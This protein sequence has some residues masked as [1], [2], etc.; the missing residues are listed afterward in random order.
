MKFSKNLKNVTFWSHH[1][2]PYQKLKRKLRNLFSPPVS[3][4][5]LD[6]H[7]HSN[8]SKSSSSINNNSNGN[9]PTDHGKE[10]L[11]QLEIE[12]KKVNDFLV[13]ERLPMIVNRFSDVLSKYKAIDFSSPF[14]V[15]LGVSLMSP[16]NER[17]QQQQQQQQQIPLQQV[18]SLALDQ[19]SSSLG[20]YSEQQQMSSVE[21]DIITS[22]QIAMEDILKQLGEL[23]QFAQLN[24][25]AIQ[26]LLSSYSKQKLKTTSNRTRKTSLT[27]GGVSNLD[28]TPSPLSSPM[29]QHA[30][31]SNIKETIDLFFNDTVKPLE[32]YS[33]SQLKKLTIEI[34]IDYQSICQSSIYILNN[35]YLSLLNSK[36]KQLSNHVSVFCQSVVNNNIQSVELILKEIKNLMIELNLSADT[37]M[38]VKTIHDCIHKSCFLGNLEM[39]EYLFKTFD[40]I[41]NIN[42]SDEKDK[43]FIHIA[44]ENG[45]ATI[46]SFLLDHGANIECNDFLSR[47]PLHLSCKGCHYECVELLVEKQAQLN[48][49]DR[50]GCT[51]LFLACRQPKNNHLVIQLL[52]KLGSLLTP[53]P[54]GRNPIHEITSKGSIENLE[55]FLDHFRSSIPNQPSLCQL[56]NCQ[57]LFGRTPLFE[58]IKNGHLESVQMLLREPAGVLIE[59]LDEEKR[60]P[61]HEAT[62]HGKKL[63]L[64]LIISHLQKDPIQTKEN[65]SRII[66][67]QD[68]DGWSALHDASFYNYTDCAKVLLEKGANPYLLDKADRSPIVHS[69]YRGNIKTSMIIMEFL[70]ANP[71]M[72]IANESTP[73]LRDSKGI[74]QPPPKLDLLNQIQQSQQIKEN[75]TTPSTITVV[76][77]TTSVNSNSS[78]GSFNSMSPPPLPNSPGGSKTKKIP[79]GLMSSVT[80][81][82]SLPSTAMKPGQII[83][84]VGNRKAIGSWSPNSALLFSRDQTTTSVEDTIGWI[85][86]VSVPVAVQLEY[87][88]VIFEGTRLDSWETL[89]EN[90]TFTPHE[91]EEF[92]DDGLFGQ[93]EEISNSDDKSLSQSTVFV[94]KGWL[95][96]DSQVRIRFGETTSTDPQRKVVSPVYLFNGKEQAGRVVVT[97]RD[98]NGQVVQSGGVMGQNYITLPISKDQSVI[99][100]TSQLM[101]LYSVHFEIYRR[102]MSS[103]MIGRSV[104]F[105]QDIQ[106]P[107]AAYRKT[108]PIVNSSFVTVGELTFFPL[109][110]LPFTHP[111]VSDVLSK[112]YWK[113]TLLI[114]HRGGGAENSR[115]VG[116]YK[117]THIKEN[118][119]LSFVTA[120]SLGAQY[121]EFDVQISRDLVPVIFHDF[122]I[123]TRDKLKIPINKLNSDYFKQ[124]S[125][126]QASQEEDSKSTSQ[127][128]KTIPLSKV[129][130]KSMLDIFENSSGTKKGLSMSSSSISPI[131]ESEQA[132]TGASGDKGNSGH[133]AG[134]GNPQELLHD[135]LATLEETFKKVPIQTGFNIEIKYPSQ[136]REAELKLNSIARNDYVDIILKT[137]F[138]LAG[139]RS[140]IFSSFD[141]DICILCSLKQPK[142]PV[143]F[144]SNAGITQHSDPR[145]NSIYEAIRF[146]KS[147][148]C[149]GIV[150]NS[151]ILCEGPPIISQVKSQG[152]MLVS[153]GSENNDPAFVDLQEAL[154]CDALIVDH[155]AYVS[156]SYNNNNK[157]NN[158]NN[159]NITTTLQDK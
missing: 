44:S 97:L 11:N 27:T 8:S 43:Q 61:L 33:T 18:Q 20:F 16:Q 68:D 12:I 129:K 74:L 134:H 22:F 1:Y 87:K 155:V 4:V 128:K 142:Y 99:I 59:T 148:H 126:S 77:P 30:H 58:C 135:S 62:A 152:L 125:N 70:K 19:S 144:L 130:S 13:Q 51:P 119:I 154:G 124:K 118:T 84:M 31:H 88:Y 36:E 3:P 39:T 105:L 98:R 89:P 145:C 109:V 47:K 133:G 83:G 146:S 7:L 55:V 86:K 159:N 96:Q 106:G 111:K 72:I 143:F 50:E 25:Q 48:S 41:V 100:Q 137:V 153:W 42:Y 110:I 60:S 15:S 28:K 71:E 24:V 14:S 37:V 52:L 151:K 116:K 120:A 149:L 158:N 21:V 32:L 131:M 114:G 122:E 10:F 35:S 81:R 34:E 140:I 115:S 85:G 6:V 56:I 92:V 103:V 57:D 123:Q 112:T 53:G 2:I 9:T 132:S 26:K 65:L 29:S 117:R 66:N 5:N 127:S 141:P 157:N 156:K 17:Q 108:I 104:I 147:A 150:T 45:H 73:T 94:E 49:L 107:Q 38:W 113:S 93:N 75:L 91:E 54:Y 76:S 40:K 78:N 139:E 95:V 80:F 46:V 23:D 102:G 69:L 138:E 82:I 64:E 101:P 79:K 136:E 90:R 63:A 121:V 67:L